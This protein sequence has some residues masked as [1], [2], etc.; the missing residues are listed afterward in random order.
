MQN[1]N[2]IIDMLEMQDFEHLLVET[3]NTVN[4]IQKIPASQG[5]GSYCWIIEIGKS[6]TPRTFFSAESMLDEIHACLEGK[7]ETV[8]KISTLLVNY[9]K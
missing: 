3:E 4:H 7:R 6:K 2:K 8:Q 9:R 1:R 5:Q